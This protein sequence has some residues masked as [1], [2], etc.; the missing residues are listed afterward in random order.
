MRYMEGGRSPQNEQGRKARPALRPYEIS[1]L[2]SHF[3][4]D[5]PSALE[6][7]TFART[8]LRDAMRHINASEV[9]D[10]RLRAIADAF[11]RQRFEM[12]APGRGGRRHG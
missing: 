7:Q 9:E 3:S 4:L 2:A 10:Q 5:T 1:D 8:M 11:R 6:L 12:S